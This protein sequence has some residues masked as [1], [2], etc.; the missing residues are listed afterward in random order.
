MNSMT[1]MI[2]PNVAAVRTLC[3]AVLALFLTGSVSAG[4]LVYQPRFADQEDRYVPP[5]VLVGFNPQPEPPARLLIAGDLSSPDPRVVFSGIEG[6]SMELLIGIGG[7]QQRLA[8]ISLIGESC[9]SRGRFP[10]YPMF[11]EFPLPDACA[12]GFRL[13]A[14]F[15]DGD[16]YYL[17]ISLNA[18]EGDVVIPPA[19]LVGFNPQPEPPAIPA[20]GLRVSLAESG[21]DT[22][23][24]DVSL[25]DAAGNEV[26]LR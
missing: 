10:I 20:I 18:S 6:G 25:A 1:R 17:T 22:L 14:R 5:A 13:M 16:I 12:G 23:T 21:S 8:S 15:T 2:S 9:G 19:N 24:V 26:P 3:L 11:R 7:G 4:S